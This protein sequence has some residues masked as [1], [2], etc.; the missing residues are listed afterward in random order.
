M[1]E[2]KPIKC[3][4]CKETKPRKDF[5]YCNETHKHDRCRTCRFPTCDGCGAVAQWPVIERSKEKGK[6]KGTWFC[7]KCR[8]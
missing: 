3:A 4:E 8:K 7:G 5:D 1:P 6:K 2:V